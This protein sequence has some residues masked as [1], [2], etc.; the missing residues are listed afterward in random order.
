ME[1]WNV[2]LEH[3]LEH[4]FSFIMFSTIPKCLAY[5][6]KDAKRYRVQFFAII[7]I[8]GTVYDWHDFTPNVHEN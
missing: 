4:V 5:V 1:L 3:I 2:F 7:A 8:K 6:R